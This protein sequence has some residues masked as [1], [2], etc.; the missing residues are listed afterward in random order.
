MKCLR[1]E[2]DEAFEIRLSLVLSSESQLRQES[3]HRRL[4]SRME[5]M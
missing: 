3:L 5:A 4:C 1:A 2:A